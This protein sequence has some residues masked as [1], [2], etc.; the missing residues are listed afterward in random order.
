MHALGYGTG[1]QGLKRVGGSGDAGLDGI[2]ALDKLGLEKVGRRTPHIAHFSETLP[3][4]GG[5]G[6]TAV[7]S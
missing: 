6:F 2:I 5:G 1:R 7:T 3:R 4:I